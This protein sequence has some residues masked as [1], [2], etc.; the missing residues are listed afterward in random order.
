LPSKS[1][2][3]YCLGQKSNSLAAEIFKDRVIYGKEALD[4]EEL[5]K[6]IVRQEQE[7]SD[8][9]LKKRSVDDC[10]LILRSYVFFTG[11]KSLQTLPAILQQNGIPCKQIQVYSTRILSIDCNCLDNKIVVLFSPSGLQSL[12]NIADLNCRWI[13]IGKTTGKALNNCGI[14]KYYVSKAPTPEGLMNAILECVNDETP[15]AE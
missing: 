7:W 4:S 11:D 9:E 10:T 8:C 12:E 2:N 3:V 13:A 15:R 1:Q 14:R 5:A 6:L